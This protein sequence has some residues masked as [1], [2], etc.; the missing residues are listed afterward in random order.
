ML[1]SVKIKN[2][3]VR[4]VLAELLGTFVLVARKRKRERAQRVS[5]MEEE[6]LV[7]SYNR[8]HIQYTHGSHIEIIASNVP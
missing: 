4:E 5:C 8:K 3:L 1:D 2:A 6:D 7:D